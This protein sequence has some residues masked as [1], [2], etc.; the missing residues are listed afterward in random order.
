MILMFG[1][2]YIVSMSHRKLYNRRENMN[3]KYFG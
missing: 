2:L 1:K 3:L